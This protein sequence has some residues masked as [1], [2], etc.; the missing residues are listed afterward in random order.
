MQ[1]FVFLSLPNETG[2]NELQF[3]SLTK[4]LLKYKSCFFNLSVINLM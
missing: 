3:F 4:I 1:I 2:W